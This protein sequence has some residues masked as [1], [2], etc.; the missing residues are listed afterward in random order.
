MEVCSQMKVRCCCASDYFFKVNY[1]I[2]T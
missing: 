1:W 2:N